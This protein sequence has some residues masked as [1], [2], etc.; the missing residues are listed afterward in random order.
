MCSWERFCAFAREP[1]R[2]TVGVD[3]RITVD[4]VAYEVDPNLAGETVVLWWG[5][6]DHELYV[7][8]SEQRH[9]PYQPVR[10]PIPLHRYRRWSRQGKPETLELGESS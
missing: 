4:G 3:A 7:E 9:G 10:G 5:L 1:E 8:H 6:F 2:R